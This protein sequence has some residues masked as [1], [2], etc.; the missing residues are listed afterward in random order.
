MS[1]AGWRRRKRGICSEG[2]PYVVITLAP[3]ACVFQGLEKC[4]FLLMD[5]RALKAFQAKK[6]N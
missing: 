3:F 1:P 6:Q 2:R 5:Q 4:V